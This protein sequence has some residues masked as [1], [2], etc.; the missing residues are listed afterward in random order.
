MIFPRQL[1]SWRYHFTR[2]NQLFGALGWPYLEGRKAWEGLGGA[3][4][5]AGLGSLV[6]SQ[7][8]P[9]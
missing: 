6:L 7:L 4:E 1:L 8:Q 2:K 3:D 9:Q 5:P